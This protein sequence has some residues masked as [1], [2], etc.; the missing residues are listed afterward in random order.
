MLLVIKIFTNL[1][2]QYLYPR[3]IGRTFVS[4]EAMRSQVAHR[5]WM[6][7]VLFS[8][9]VLSVLVTGNRGRRVAS[10]TSTRHR[11]ACHPPNGVTVRTTSCMACQFLQGAVK[12]TGF[13]FLFV[14]IRLDISSMSQS[15]QYLG[16]TSY[17]FPHP[18]RQRILLHTMVTKMPG[19]LDFHE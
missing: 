10:G 2:K 4:L 12:H 7:C 6:R 1:G 3:C 17:V 18:N 15:I 11:P 14:Q 13:I 16:P 9:Y 8:L 5:Q 19:V